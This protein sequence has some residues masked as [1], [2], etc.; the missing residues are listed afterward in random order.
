MYLTYIEPHYI[1]KPGSKRKRK[2][3]TP[4][5]AVSQVTQEMIE[6]ISY[7]SSGKLYSQSGTTC[8]QCR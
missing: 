8:H 2:T 5:L 7:S 6:N 4:R 1:K 3:Y